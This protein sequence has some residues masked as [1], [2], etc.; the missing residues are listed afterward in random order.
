M[1][2]RSDGVTLTSARDLRSVTPDNLRFADDWVILVGDLKRCTGG[3]DG[4]NVLDIARHFATALARYDHLM[5]LGGDDTLRG[6]DGCD[7]LQG[8][9]GRDLLAGGGG[10]GMFVFTPGDHGRDVIRDFAAGQDHIDLSGLSDVQVSLHHGATVIT[11]SDMTLILRS[12]G[13]PDPGSLF[14]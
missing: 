11:T 7:L 3:D 9:A 5:G 14:L 6:G 1:T 13:H 12:V 2:L 4:D 8:C 10:A